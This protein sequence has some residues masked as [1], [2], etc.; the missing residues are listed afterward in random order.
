[1]TIGD[2]IA[3]QIFICCDKV[4]WD[5]FLLVLLHAHIAVVKPGKIFKKGISKNIWKGVL[6]EELNEY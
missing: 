2:K 6:N 1:M 5:Q 4:K 3:I